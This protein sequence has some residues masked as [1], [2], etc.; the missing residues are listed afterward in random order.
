MLLLLLVIAATLL[1]LFFEEIRDSLRTRR[2]LDGK[3]VLITGAAG[4]LGCEL[5]RQFAA[6]GARLL[7]WDVRSD[8][9]N[10]VSEWL[11][12]EHGVSPAD[13][14]AR[15]VDV[16]DA[17]AVAAAMSEAE[18][19]IGRP[20]VLVNNAAVTRGR[21]VMD[22]SVDEIERSFGV[23]VL[24]QWWC[25]KAALPGMIAGGGGTVV[26]VSSVMAHI[27]SARMADYSATKAAVAQLHHCLRW[28]LAGTGVT[29][30]L[31]QPFMIGDSPLF[32]G[33]KPIRYAAL[34][35]LVPLL[36]AASV[37][38]A[39]VDGV[40]AGREHVVLPWYLRNILALLPLL[41][42]P[43]RDLVCDAGGAA[44][45][46]QSFIGADMYE[47]PRRTA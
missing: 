30:M 36:S 13:V 44:T 5:A 26:T 15:L 25:A 45:A 6:A 27:P 47:P 14:R 38:A 35:P 33:G 9:L 19:Q 18:A 46:M 39:V 12:A 17:A 21:T 2:S 16:R 20:S 10:S 24:S 42:A 37:A 4:S 43:L 34:R 23:N 41:P 7:L 1:F 32:R 22:S 40:R 11:V 28:E 8:A 3:V 31:V 29:C